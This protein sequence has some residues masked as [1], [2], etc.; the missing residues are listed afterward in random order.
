MK[1]Q[2]V[3]DVYNRGKFADSLIK[4]I[5]RVESPFS[6]GVDAKWG[7][8]KTTFVQSFLKP[9]ATSVEL[10]IVIFDCFENE[11]AGDPFFS[12][13]QQILM[14]LTPEP[15]TEVLEES[16]KRI[17]EMATK[18]AKSC[19][20]VMVKAFSK[21]VLKQD[22]AE[23]AAE[24]TNDETA[25]A[26]ADE[27]T[28]K[29]TEYIANKLQDG[30]QETLAKQ[31]FRTEIENLA[32]VLS[33]NN[34]I[35]VVIDELDRCTPKFALEVLESIKYILNTKGIIFLFA[36]HRDQLC[37]SVKHE[38]GQQIDA[39]IY[40]HK[41]VNLDL[42]LPLFDP[43]DDNV[44]FKILAKEF[45][46]KFS[47]EP[48]SYEWVVNLLWRLRGVYELEA[49][50]IERIITIFVLTEQNYMDRRIQLLLTIWYVKSPTDFEKL[51]V[52]KLDTQTRS[53]LK[54]DECIKI[55]GLETGINDTSDNVIPKD[56]VDALVGNAPPKSDSIFNIKQFAKLITNLSF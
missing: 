20:V 8:G 40:L 45:I 24:F 28:A 3:F 35:L 15:K 26:I 32:S 27:T 25:D 34:K 49:R 19:A 14:D 51:L 12:I 13:T 4:L 36:Y 38:F 29:L 52:G 48:K 47:G 2:K 30:H 7:A 42:R 22:L 41:F 56:Y 5:R 46:E 18:V 16:K 55:L 54:I 11:R 10:P 1:E 43:E 53:V 44:G 39:N 21:A 9:A 23:I 33:T 50:T 31:S 6:I 17:S 37:N